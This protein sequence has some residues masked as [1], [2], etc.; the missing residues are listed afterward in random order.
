MRTTIVWSIGTSMTLIV[1]QYIATWEEGGGVAWGEGVGW[2]EIKREMQLYRNCLYVYINYLNA[3]QTWNRR[4]VKDTNYSI[5]S[6]SKH[7]CVSKRLPYIIIYI[8]MKTILRGPLSWIILFD[9]SLCSFEKSWVIQNEMN[10]LIC[11]LELISFLNQLL[12]L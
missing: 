3:I 6:L 4:L 9:W 1:V 12:P 11:V 2:G 5:P 7:R 10:F 8:Q